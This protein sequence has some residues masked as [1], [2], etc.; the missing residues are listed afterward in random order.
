MVVQSLPG[1]R[2]GGVSFGE[3]LVQG[4]KKKKGNHGHNY[5]SSSEILVSNSLFF[6]SADSTVTLYFHFKQSTHAKKKICLQSFPIHYTCTFL[7]YFFVNK[8]HTRTHKELSW[9]V[10]NFLLLWSSALLSVLVLISLLLSFSVQFLFREV[11]L[12]HCRFKGYNA[13][14]T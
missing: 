5:P 13:I 3:P 6:L 4:Q 12:P 11:L 2:L 10:I 14:N 7:F 1:V 9:D 8:R